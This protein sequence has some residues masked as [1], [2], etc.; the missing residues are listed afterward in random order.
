[1]ATDDH[2]YNMKVML[3]NAVENQQMLCVAKP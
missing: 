1:M 3:E 2:P